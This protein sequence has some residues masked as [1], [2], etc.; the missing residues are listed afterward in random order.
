L[1]N[2]AIPIVTFVA[3]QFGVLLSGA[4]VTETVFAWPGIGRIVIEAINTRDYPVLQAAVLVSAFLILILNLL[5]DL[6]YA[7][8]DPRI[9]FSSTS[10]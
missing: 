3:L 6:L 4:V 1:R 9:A 8:L 2:A 10:G 5:V 7:W